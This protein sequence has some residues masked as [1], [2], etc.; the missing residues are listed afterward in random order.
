MGQTPSIQTTT[1]SSQRIKPTPGSSGKRVVRKNMISVYSESNNQ[2]YSLKVTHNMTIAQLKAMLPGEKIQIKL[3][4]K[5][6]PNSGTLQE[7]GISEL[8][9]LRIVS[10]EKNSD[11]TT[12]T[13]DSLGDSICIPKIIGPKREVQAKPTKPNCESVLSC[14]SVDDFQIGLNLPSLAVP[15]AILKRSYKYKAKKTLY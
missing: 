14:S 10:D 15:D 12:S 4:E 9:L 2:I 3:D 11:K 5:L 6:L 8:C 7:L 13:V 1:N